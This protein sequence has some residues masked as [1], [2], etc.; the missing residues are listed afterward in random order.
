MCQDLSVIPHYNTYF[1]KSCFSGLITTG[2]KQ[3]KMS[4]ARLRAAILIVSETAFN[5]PSTDKSE[6]T[7][8]DTFESGSVDKWAVEETQIVPDDVLSIQ[9]TLTQWCDGMDPVNLVVTT[10]GT[11]FTAKD[12]TPE[13]VTPLIHKQA[14]GIM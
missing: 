11:G 1:S 14:P 12:I 2:N 4:S 3:P 5:D 7:L 6:D 9:R 10:G 8:R 13:A